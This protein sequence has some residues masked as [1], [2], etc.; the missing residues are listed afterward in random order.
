MVL[1]HS[2]GL[3]HL[4]LGAQNFFNLA[5][6]H[7]LLDYCLCELLHLSSQQCRGIFNLLFSSRSR[8]EVA[9]P[10]IVLLIRVRECVI[11][12]YAPGDVFFLELFNVLAWGAHHQ[13]HVCFVVFVDILNYTLEL[14]VLLFGILVGKV[15]SHGN[16]NVL[17]L[18]LS[19]IIIDIVYE[20]YHFIICIKC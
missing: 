1:V 9:H 10:P 11:I 4:L 16:Q 8:G 7:V 12:L 2:K 14:F 13:G 5:V 20:V 6:F 3:K 18:L 19:R 17:S 15:T